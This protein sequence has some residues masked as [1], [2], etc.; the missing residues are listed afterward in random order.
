MEGSAHDRE[1]ELLSSLCNPIEANQKIENRKAASRIIPRG[2]H[3]CI[4]FL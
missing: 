2:S 4:S 3:A 1:K